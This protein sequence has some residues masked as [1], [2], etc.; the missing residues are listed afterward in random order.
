MRVFTTGSGGRVYDK[1]CSI[2][3]ALVLAEHFSF[4][5]AAHVLGVYLTQSEYLFVD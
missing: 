5:R 4:S 1:S 3:Q 2:F